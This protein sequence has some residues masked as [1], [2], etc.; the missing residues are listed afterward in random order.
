M[1]FMEFF[2]A[3]SLCREGVNIE[4][5]LCKFKDEDRL[6]AV[7]TYMAGLF[8]LNPVIPYSSDYKGVT[9]K[10]LSLLGN[11]Q[12]LWQR[13]TSIQKVFRGIMQKPSDPGQ[14]QVETIHTEADIQVTE[15]EIGMSMRRIHLLLEALRA[16][17]EKMRPQPI[18]RK[19]FVPNDRDAVGVNTISQ[20]MEFQDC[21]VDHIYIRGWSFA[22]K[23]RIRGE[24]R[25]RPQQENMFF[26]V[27]PYSATKPVKEKN[28][29]GG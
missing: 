24:N 20:L 28:R 19:V 14:Q 13:D 26:F 8:S 5:E 12:S 21:S 18:I 16:S 10:F 11:D 15:R 3:A 17:G 1:S 23:V 9:E 22:T 6:H 2:C 7:V 29:I 27:F 4:E 25:G